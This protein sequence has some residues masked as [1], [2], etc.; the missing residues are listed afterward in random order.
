M[1]LALYKEKRNFASTPEPQGKE[2]GERDALRF[3]VQKHD[4]SALHYDFR[5]ELQ[6]VLKS[7]AVPKGPSLQ[8]ADKRLAMMVADHPFDYRNFEGIIPDGN[9]GAGVVMVWDEGTYT[10]YEGESLPKKDQEKKLHEGLQKGS[11]KFNLYGHKLRGQFHLMRL[12]KGGKAA[13]LLIKVKDEFATT[14][15]VTG[16]TA[17]VKSGRSLAQIAAAGGTALQHPEKTTRPKEKAQK[18]DPKGTTVSASKKSSPQKPISAPVHEQAATNTEHADITI[19]G[20]TV[21]LTSLHKLYWKE[22]GFTKGDTIRYYHE[23]LP[24]LFPYLK[25]KPQS[26]HRHPNGI[27]GTRFFQKDMEGKLPDWI[28]TY[29]D[30]SESTGQPVHYLVCNSEAAVLYMANLGCIELHPFHSRTGKIN[31]PDYCVLDLDPHTGSPFEEVIEAAQVV[32]QVLATAGVKGYCKT[33]GSSGLHIYIPMGARYTYE[34]VK[35]FAETVVTLVQQELPH[36]TSLERAPAK[37]KNK[38]YLDW[39]QNALTQTAASAYSLR[40]KKGMPVSAPLHWD[41]VKKGLQP[42]TWNARNIMQR[43][44]AEGDLFAPVLQEK[45]NLKK[46]MES[47]N[48]VLKK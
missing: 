2:K 18:A 22:E 46:S 37:R 36:T 7:W 21:H 39:M 32:R 25:N 41:E 9:Y 14:G 5:L 8:P 43:L 3:V 20:R 42:A 45:T 27:S 17:S 13:W 30:F 4:A 29:E 6:G 11:V 28:P 31:N 47:L 34:A 26:L 19:K 44:R 10:A 24:Y 1:G 35:S 40:P 48:A 15:D 12:K 33:S 16:E 38:I 23:I